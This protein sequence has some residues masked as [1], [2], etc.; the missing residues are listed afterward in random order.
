MEHIVD[1]GG[2]ELAGQGIYYWAGNRSAPDLH[3]ADVEKRQDR[4]VFKPAIP[5]VPQL[6]I[7][8]DGR[9]L[10]FSLIER[11]SQELMLIEKWH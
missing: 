7:S 1:P 2:W 5:A 4:V 9:W 3:Y 8:P 10:C 6:A 11:N